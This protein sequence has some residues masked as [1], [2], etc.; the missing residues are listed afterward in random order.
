MKITGVKVNYECVERRGG[1]VEKVYSDTSYANKELGW[2]TTHTLEDMITS[3]WAWE[4]VLQK[5]SLVT[6]K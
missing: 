1:D 4:Q 3:A 6:S 2:K 5:K